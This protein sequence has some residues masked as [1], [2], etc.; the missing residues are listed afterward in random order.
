[1]PNNRTPKTVL[2]PNSF[3]P[4]GHP[5]RPSNTQPTGKEVS[6]EEISA[7]ERRLKN[8]ESLRKLVVCCS[9]YTSHSEDDLARFFSSKYPKK[10]E[11]TTT[12]ADQVRLLFW[13]YWANDGTQQKWGR[14]EGGE[15]ELVNMAV[16]T[17]FDEFMR[18]FPSNPM[19]QGYYPKISVKRL[20][21]AL[22]NWSK[23]RPGDTNWQPVDS[24]TVPQP[25][26]S[27]QP[28]VLP[29][30]ISEESLNKLLKR[31]SLHDKEVMICLA[32][33][34][35]SETEVAALFMKS[36][37]QNLSEEIGTE[38]TGNLV[39]AAFMKMWEV[40]KFDF[41]PWSHIE[42]TLDQKVSEK[43]DGFREFLDKE[44]LPWK[45]ARKVQKDP[46]VTTRTIPQW[47]TN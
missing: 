26:S 12:N 9:L 40:N 46:V 35:N 42:S 23:P 21:I 5:S 13:R 2:D 31:L 41:Q 24:M 27:T 38:I 16:V 47:Q 20:G 44:R 28:T 11:A 32:F 45:R 15:P 34:T 30:P 7:L 10:L 29:S 1:M 17:R 8:H 36:V 19:I 22:P 33:F 6:S 25:S 14:Y 37:Y 39:D 43:V 3:Y 18:K 4:P